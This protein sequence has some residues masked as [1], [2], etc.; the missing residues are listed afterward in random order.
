[1]PSYPP[2]SPTGLPSS[3][4]VNRQMQMLSPVETYSDTT[5]RNSSSSPDAMTSEKP[6]ARDIFAD[7]TIPLS[8]ATS[9]SSSEENPYA[10]LA[11]RKR[12]GFARLFC[13]LG[14]EERAR[15]R[16]DRHLEFVKVGEEVHWTEY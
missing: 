11:P 2:L 16:A 4:R 5:P 13:C 6:K 15:R 10:G 12:N 14:R 3:P 7:A 8:P 9:T 1:M